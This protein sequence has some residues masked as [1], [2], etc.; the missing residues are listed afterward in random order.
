MKHAVSSHSY[1]TEGPPEIETSLALRVVWRVEVPGREPYE[2]EEE[3]SGPM[4]SVPGVSSAAA[5]AG[6]RCA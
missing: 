1:G 5:T 4:G 2:L 6:T 3:R